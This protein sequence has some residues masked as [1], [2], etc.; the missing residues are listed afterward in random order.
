[1]RDGKFCKK[2]TKV[3]R[4]RFLNSLNSNNVHNQGFF[5]VQNSDLI[6]LTC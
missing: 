4:L 2:K 3:Q 6:L 1:M 5:F